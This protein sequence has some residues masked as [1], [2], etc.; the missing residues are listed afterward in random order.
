MKK[1]H[2][3]MIIFLG[4]TQFG[5]AGTINHSLADV[6]RGS[7]SKIEKMSDKDLEKKHA[8]TCDEIA[9][10]KNNWKIAKRAFFECTENHPY[11]WEHLNGV[12]ADVSWKYPCHEEQQAVIWAEKCYMKQVRS[13]Y[14]I[15]NEI[16]RR[17]KLHEQCQ[18]DAITCTT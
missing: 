9:Q 4:I 17:Q 14:K 2:I 7:G 3:T 15:I 1:T 8:K 10:A 18:T 13:L 12:F 6:R 16:N 11:Y 5:F